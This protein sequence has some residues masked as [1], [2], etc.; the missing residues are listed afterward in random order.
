[1]SV[2]K[3]YDLKHNVSQLETLSNWQTNQ[4]FGGSKGSYEVGRYIGIALAIAAELI[5]G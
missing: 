3:I 2:I 5:P 4:V 1:M